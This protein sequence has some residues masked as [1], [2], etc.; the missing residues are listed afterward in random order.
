MTEYTIQSWF[1]S[2]DDEV[3]DFDENFVTE[4]KLVC[5]D[6]FLGGIMLVGPL[7]LPSPIE[8]TIKVFRSVENEEIE[9]IQTLGPE[10]LDDCEYPLVEEEFDEEKINLQ[11][12]LNREA[13]LSENGYDLFLNYDNGGTTHLR[14]QNSDILRGIRWGIKFF[15]GDDDNDYC[16]SALY[17]NGVKIENSNEYLDELN[18]DNTK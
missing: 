12:T 8:D 3:Y 18:D 6:E 4:T 14:F 16:I 5:S 15:N 9:N 11:L 13:V 17:H 7:I 1:N 10:E 2:E